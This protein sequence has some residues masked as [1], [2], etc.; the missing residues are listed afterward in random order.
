[1]RFYRIINRKTGKTIIV[2][3]DH[4]GYG[5]LEGLEDIVSV[6]KRIVSGG[7]D[8]LI[9]QPGV[10]KVLLREISVNSIGLIIR[11][12]GVSAFNRDR[13][14]YE[15]STYSV[16]N[17]LKLGA[18]AIIASLYIGGKYEFKSMNTVGR[19][20]GKCDK[21]GVPCIVEVFPSIDR[22]KSFDD[23]EGVVKA[24]RIAAELGADIVK[25]YLPPDYEIMKKAVESSFIP[26]VLAG[27]E[28]SSPIEVL[29]LARLA[30]DAG[31]TGICFGRK[32]FR[33]KEPEKMVKALS[34]IVHD[35]MGVENALKILE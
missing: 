20:C 6:I 10:I 13:G 16:E 2:P 31:L 24:I 30:M 27:G 4:G 9:L 7:V 23:P 29:K 19:I 28:A 18:D 11:V 25:A 8:A 12:T 34:L 17:V 35:N 5:V 32:V 22:F 14:L 33:Y 15:T 21:W 26:I 1:M 3:I